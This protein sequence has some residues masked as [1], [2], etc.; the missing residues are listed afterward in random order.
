LV[1]TATV[2]YPYQN[3]SSFCEGSLDG[4]VA[5]DRMKR[6]LARVVAADDVLGEQ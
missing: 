3:Q 5:A 2:A 1:E 6:A 4:G